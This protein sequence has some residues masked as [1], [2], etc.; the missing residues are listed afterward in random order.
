VEEGPQLTIRVK[1][2]GKPIPPESLQ[3]IFDPLVQLSEKS[4]IGIETPSTNLGLGLFIARE[5][6]TGHGGTL[7]VSS[8]AV[9]GTVFVLRVP[10]A[11]VP[12]SAN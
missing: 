3:V 10:Q 7:D 2:Q 12:L 9:N 11:A 4:A 6:A 1:N 5:V 8:D